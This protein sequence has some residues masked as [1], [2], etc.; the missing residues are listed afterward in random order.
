MSAAESTTKPRLSREAIAVERRYRNVI[1]LF[2]AGRLGNF[3]HERHVHVANIL[4]HLPYGRELMHLGLQVMAFRNFIPDKY[5][6]AVT[7]WHWDTLDGT[8]PDVDAFADIPGGAD[9]RR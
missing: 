7:D 9:G 4:R 3:T 6:A 2:L 5:D 8:L 1:T